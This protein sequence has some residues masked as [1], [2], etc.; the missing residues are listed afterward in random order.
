MAKKKK[1]KKGPVSDDQVHVLLVNFENALQSDSGASREMLNAL[2][3]FMDKHYTPGGLNHNKGQELIQQYEQQKVQEAKDAVLE[4]QR[5]EQQRVE[6]AQRTREER[7]KAVQQ[8]EPFPDAA[9]G[10][11]SVLGEHFH[12][13]YTFLPFVDNEPERRSP[14]PLT[15]DELPG[16]RDRFTGV[17]DLELETLTPLL[18]CTPIAHEENNGHRAY[19]ALTI[20]DDVIVPATGVRGAL[21]SLMTIIAGGT[22]GYL[23]TEVWLC[24]G[25]DASLGPAG[26]NS[27]P[28]TPKHCFLARVAKPGDY[29]RGGQVTLGQT[30]L[31]KA[32]GLERSFQAAFGGRLD[33]ARPRSGKR[34]D[35]LWCD[36][37]ATSLSKRQ[38][39]KHCW[40]VKLSGRP[41][42]RK[43]KREGI[44]CSTGV[45]LELPGLLWG[46][47]AGRNRHGDH[48][49]LKK[50]DLVWLEPSNE[51][52]SQIRSAADVKSIQWARWGRTGERLLD[53]VRDRHHHLLPDAFNVDGKVDEVTDLFGQVPREDLAREVAAGKQGPGPAGP[54]AARVRPE[55]L[56]FLDA[57][58]SGL[59][60]QVPLAPL[61]P[62]HP[63]CAAFYRDYQQ[64][65]VIQNKDLPL[66]GYKVYR[67]SQEQGEAAPWLFRNQGVY[68]DRGGIKDA[69]QKVNK[70]CDLLKAGQRGR[71]RLAC[72]ALSQRELALLLA[73]CTV[74]WR[75]GGGKPLGLG[76]CR[77]HKI[78]VVGED[79]RDLFDPMV[80]GK[81]SPA[82]LP[83]HLDALLS[84]QDRQRLGVWQASQQPVE[85]L[86]Y[87]RAVVENRNK[88]NRG[89][90]VWFSRHATR[91]KGQPGL[92]VLWTDGELKERAKRGNIDPQPLPRFDAADPA[93]G[94]LLFGHDLFSGDNP[95]FRTLAQNR[96]T[97]NKKLV[98]FDPRRHRR[99][100]DQSGGKQGQT[101]ESR[102]KERDRTRKR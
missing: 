31:I 73:C 86:R 74:D 62:P 66:R 84:E 3:S 10:H 16:E 68:D 81:D 48:P 24:Q 85:H 8:G 29:E 11:P 36:E 77:V 61:A 30:R 65:S 87:P 46:A 5:A 97:M 22:L 88:K 98:P 39:E 44:F 12:N 7:R 55:N 71:L 47:Y 82:P 32:E 43:G 95:D 63:G 101:K 69:R 100:G 78:T 49:E 40:Q 2:T 18:S 79:G 42:N 9:P 52:C 20:G 27:A 92:E 91:K 57:A 67:T 35:H 60:T 89:G 56:V 64:I 34:L 21:R 94:D 90:H 75:L 102:A 19:R 70:T 59:Q 72:R 76:A 51:G 37:G 53:I 93:Y 4:K 54:L 23:D 33:D 17:L 41:I 26:K 25:R 1:T 6:Q 80:F 58:K 28:K 83:E 15:V 13:P 50:G 14:T 38:D 96:Q 45:T 99:D